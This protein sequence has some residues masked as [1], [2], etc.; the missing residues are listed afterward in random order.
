VLRIHLVDPAEVKI[1]F[2][3]LNVGER[4]KGYSS[5]VTSTARKKIPHHRFFQSTLLNFY[6]AKRKSSSGIVVWGYVPFHTA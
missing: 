3:Y 2:P 5:T 1:L 4:A 6:R